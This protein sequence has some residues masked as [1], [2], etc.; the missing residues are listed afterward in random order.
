MENTKK[1]THVARYAATTAADPDDRS[2]LIA[3]LECYAEIVDNEAC[4]WDEFR[5]VDVQLFKNRKTGETVVEALIISGI[6]TVKFI[7]RI[8]HFGTVEV[9]GDYWDLGEVVRAEFNDMPAFEL[10]AEGYA[11]AEMELA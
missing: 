2:E 1:S 6:P 4:N 5:P 9:T 8:S 3:A 11:E 7:A 10:W